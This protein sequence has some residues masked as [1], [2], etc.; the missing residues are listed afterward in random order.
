MATSLKR[1]ALRTIKQGR[2]TIKFIKM[3]RDR[4]VNTSKGE[5]AALSTNY[6]LPLKVI[7]AGIIRHD[8]FCASDSVDFQLAV[9][10][11][12]FTVR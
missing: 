1:A 5:I 9:I 3:N 4:T 2:I 7:N 10:T 6:R 11:Y 12:S 8:A